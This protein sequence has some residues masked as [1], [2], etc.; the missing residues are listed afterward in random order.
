MARAMTVGRRRIRGVTYPVVLGALLVLSISASVTVERQVTQL[1]R[2][3]EAELLFRGQAYVA[4][5]R[6]YYHALPDHALPGQKRYPTS[7]DELITDPRFAHRRHLRQLYADP[8]TGEPWQLIR[9]PDGGIAGVASHST[10]APRK[11]CNFPRGF[12]HFEAAERYRDWQFVYRPE[13]P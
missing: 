10:Q 13:A 5:I 11:Q 3:Q 7:L 2:D 12:E 8:L 9:A 4:A 6:S 1:R